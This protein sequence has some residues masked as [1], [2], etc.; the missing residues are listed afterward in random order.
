VY[1]E[2]GDV[3]E[4]RKNYE[5][6][7]ELRR[8]MGSKSQLALT[9]NDLGEVF[10]VQGDFAAARKQFEESLTIRSELGERTN[11]GDCQLFLASLAL[12]EGRP[13]EAELLSRK[14]LEAYKTDEGAGAEAQARAYL[15]RS[16]LAQGQTDKA[17]EALAGVPELAK[18]SQ[19]RR[20]CFFVDIVSARVR[21]SL[22]KHAEAEAI[23]KRALTETKAS[24]SVR[25]QLE[26]RLALGE[27]ELKSGKLSVARSHLEALAREARAKGFT[28]IAKK[29]SA[30]GK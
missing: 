20:V 3:T 17:Q 21:A 16:L 4:A 27:L 14:A 2:Q 28:L 29:A 1:L 8:E 22:G 15:A 7:L 25:Y 30:T 11:V 26:T 5:Q 12:E 10:L 6:A 13:S 24:D 18:R 9:L 19:D 23:L